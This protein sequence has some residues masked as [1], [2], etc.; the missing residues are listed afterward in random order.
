MEFIHHFRVALLLASLLL[1]EVS[2]SNPYASTSTFFPPIRIGVSTSSS[3]ASSPSSSSNVYYPNP[4]LLS[5]G[6]S[7]RPTT[8]R[9]KRFPSSLLAFATEKFRPQGASAAVPGAQ[10]AAAATAN[11]NDPTEEIYDDEE[12]KALFENDYKT[13][14]SGSNHNNNNN[15]FYSVT[16]AASR[17]SGNMPCRNEYEAM[18]SGFH[19]S[20]TLPALMSREEEIAFDDLEEA[21]VVPCAAVAVSS[22]TTASFSSMSSPAREAT[23]NQ[24]KES[25]KEQRQQQQ[26]STAPLSLSFKKAAPGRP[27][28]FW[29]NMICG[30]VSR[31]VA[32]TIM[33]PANTLKTLL[34]QSNAPPMSSYLKQPVQQLPV[35]FR[36]AGANFILSVPH[37]AINFAVLELVRKQMAQRVRR[38]QYLA[39]REDKL[40][41]AMDFMSSAISTICC[42]VVSTPQMMITDNIMAGNFQNLPEAV[43]G[44]AS[45]GKGLSGFYARGW[46]PGLVGKIPSYVSTCVIV[47]VQ[48]SL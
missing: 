26:S 43:K 31:S 23:M 1:Q 9:P 37:G 21:A 27:L 12:W 40:G 3:A 20:L 8:R 15:D 18:K 47:Q 14:S 35:L 2:S 6:G 28:V 25:K 41:P 11:Q 45:Q 34:Q 36:G 22:K 4:S 29:E 7:L 44:L 16:Y 30:A 38:I 39:D 33:H 42:S 19:R 48:L 13:G 17:K 32:Q 24:R 10:K 5:R 46:W